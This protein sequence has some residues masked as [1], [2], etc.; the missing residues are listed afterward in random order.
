[1]I[2][3]NKSIQTGELKSNLSFDIEKYI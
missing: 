1:L 3:L 2:S